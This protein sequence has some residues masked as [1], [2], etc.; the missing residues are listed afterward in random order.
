MDRDTD[1]SAGWAAG[2]L[3]SGDVAGGNRACASQVRGTAGMSMTALFDELSFGVAVV[4]VAGRLLYASRS[5]RMQLQSGCGLR[6]CGESVGAELP[7][8]ASA[9]RKALEGATAGRRGYLTFGSDAG[10]LDVAVLPI[11]SAGIDG[12]PSA[13]LVFEKSAGCGG[14]AL[15]FFARACRLTRSEQSVLAELCDGSSVIEAASRMGTSVHTSRTHVRNILVKTGQQNLRALI[16]RIGMLPPVGAR[17]A[18]APTR[19]GADHAL[20]AA[21]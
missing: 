6:L 5:A 19:S 15:Y 20:A 12:V 13:A 11:E 2:G 7:A 16:R 18:I 17:F 9:L 3:E 21:A 4:D 8:E 10:K 1:C 14:L